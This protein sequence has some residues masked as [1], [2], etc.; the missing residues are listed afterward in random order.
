MQIILFSIAFLFCLM[1]SHVSYAEHPRVEPVEL[2]KEYQIKAAM[3]YKVTWFV[4]WKTKSFVDKN[5]PINLCIHEPDPFGS[6]IDQLVDGHLF[7]KNK[8]R[9]SILRIEHLE[10]DHSLAD[11]HVLF[12]PKES[13]ISVP[14]Q[15]GLLIVTEE[16]SI[17]T[18]QAHINFV[19]K[20]DHVA[21]EINMGNLNKSQIRISSRLLKLARIVGN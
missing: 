15:P 19:T 3:L 21:L 14:L 20:K 13:N 10:E 11:C 5:S 7:G 2:S 12:I 16:Q 6:F 17:L 8:R 9:I 4:R 1:T 18:K